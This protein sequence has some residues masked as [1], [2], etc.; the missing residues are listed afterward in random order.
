MAKKEIPWSTIV[1]VAAALTCHSLVL[2]GNMNTAAM[3]SK[4]GHSTAGWSHVGQ[5]LG[6]SLINELDHLMGKVSTGLTS[7]VT[8]T[9]QIKSGLDT[10]ISLVG[11]STDASLSQVKHK[12]E[13]I[14]F[15]TMAL[16]AASK[17]GWPGPKAKPSALLQK[18]V[19]TK[20]DAPRRNLTA[21]SEQDVVFMMETFHVRVYP[22]RR[23]AQTSKLAALAGGPSPREDRDEGEEVFG[24]LTNPMR[25]A[26]DLQNDKEIVG[27]CL[28]NPDKAAPALEVYLRDHYEEANAL[29]HEAGKEATEWV[30][31]HIDET[32]SQLMGVVN[33]KIDAFLAMIRPA[34]EQIGKWLHSFGTK[35]QTTIEGFSSTLDKVQKIFDKLMKQVTTPSGIEDMLRETFNLFDASQTGTIS[36]ADLKEVGE[37]YG[38]TALVGE[39][40]T[41]LI[42]KYDEDMDGELNKGEYA[43][44]VE[45]ADITGA[46]GVVLRAYSKKLAQISGNVA[47]AKKRDEVAH[48]VVA[49]LELVCSKNMTKVGWVSEALTNGSLPT[50]FTADLLK[51]MAMDVDNPA[52]LMSV[53]PG[54]ILMGEMLRIDHHHVG[55]AMELMSQPDFWESEGFDLKDQPKAVERVTKWATEVAHKEAHSNLYALFGGIQGQ[56]HLKANG[57]AHLDAAVLEAMPAMAASMVKERSRVHQATK[58]AH[59]AH[60]HASLFSSQSSRVLFGELFGGSTAGSTVEDPEAAAVVNSGVEARPETLEFASFLAINSSDTAKRFQEYTFEYMGDS[61]SALDSFA[62]Q[63][64][65]MVKKTQ[66]FLNTMQHFSSKKGIDQLEDMMKSFVAKGEKKVKK[67]IMEKVYK[68]QDYVDA[69][70]DLPHS[71]T[72]PSMQSLKDADDDF[73]GGE[74]F[75]KVKKVLDKLQAIL[76][77]VIKDMKFAKK[78]VSA[79]SKQLHSI[80]DTFEAKGPPIFESTSKLYSVLWQVYYGLFVTLTSLI[81]FY[82]FWSNGW[83]GGTVTDNED[84]VAPTG[85]MG[86]CRMCASGC[87]VCLKGCHDN[88]M[89]FWSCILICEVI[90]LVLFIVAIVLTLL[91]GIK[92]F[93]GAG[94]SSIY[95]L[96]DPAICAGI[97][98]VMQGWLGTFWEN[99][100]GSISD[101]CSQ[102]SLLTC[103]LIQEKRMKSVLYT[104]AGSMLAAV[105]SFQMIVDTA[106]MHEQSRWVRR[107]DEIESKMGKDI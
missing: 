9:M 97:L 7:V 27:W 12:T 105:L 101:A 48:A 76:P 23:D 55:K 74:I 67:I 1:L 49:Y 94:C 53:E 44:F 80:F 52:K 107:V 28:K 60:A 58:R 39:K 30:V 19:L 87:S 4:L 25:S 85:F 83:F 79:V 31:S 8:S 38:I 91:S 73:F 20:K 81:L 68:A 15:Q 33:E 96:A 98:D 10:A 37:V 92:A 65:A 84:Y 104:T 78:E 46:T 3:F 51:N 56:A 86:K 32:I 106:R 64:Q 70:F 82:A 95:F 2:L 22:P 29:Y 69:H 61:S 47:A 59:R 63:I 36:S 45:D 18:L 40:A 5:H 24:E 77:E 72:L 99:G 100:I 26:A 35:V 54:P 71:M 75:M 66:N 34:L 43:L 17:N 93:M 62:T 11:S 6:H 42:K 50:A 57:T 13:M 102:E 21:P 41:T 88:A 16:A 14:A 89:C 90:V 103:Q